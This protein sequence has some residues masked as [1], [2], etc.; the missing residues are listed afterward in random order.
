MFSNPLHVWLRCNIFT[1][2]LQQRRTSQPATTG[3]LGKNE[4]CEN[5]RDYVR[6]IG[7]SYLWR[8]AKAELDAFQPGGRLS[9]EFI[10]FA[11]CKLRGQIDMHSGHVV[12]YCSIAGIDQKAP[13]EIKIFIDEG[14]YSFPCRNYRN[15]EEWLFFNA[16]D[17]MPKDIRLHDWRCYETGCSTYYLCATCQK[18]K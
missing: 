14:V 15:C 5:V 6:G 1:G 11:C 13:R 18:T 8:H 12:G 4:V 10:A 9:K 16:K 17:F 3:Q 2:T 7:E